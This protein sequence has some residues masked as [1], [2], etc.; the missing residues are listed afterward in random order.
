[1]LFP[2]EFFDIQFEFAERAQALAGV[3]LERALLDYTN[4]Y[5]RFGCGRHFDTH[6]ATW[7]AYLA[8]LA[9]SHDPRGWTFQFYLA[10]AETKTAPPVVTTVGCFSCALQESGVVRLHFENADASGQSPLHRTSVQ[11]RRAELAELFDHMKRN[12]GA[13]VEVAG[14]SWLYNLEAYRRL[15]PPHYVSSGKVV[16]RFRSMPLWGQFVGHRGPL[17]VARARQLLD[18]L[19]AVLTIGQLAQAFPLQP[20]A[21]RGPARLFYDHYRV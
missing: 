14:T 20:L 13:S 11:Q 2:Q 6:H 19:P 7:R 1:V 3:P 5:V 4:F 8:G 10:D 12:L 18:A 15:F 16:Q 17:K 21:V 9:R